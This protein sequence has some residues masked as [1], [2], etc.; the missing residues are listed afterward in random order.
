MKSVAKQTAQIGLLHKARVTTNSM[1]KRHRNR[2]NVRHENK[3]VEKG[4]GA[5]VSSF[6][7]NIGQELRSTDDLMNW[8]VFGNTKDKLFTSYNGDF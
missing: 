7:E 3:Q 6:S 5:L 8:I 2:D 4:A 1:S